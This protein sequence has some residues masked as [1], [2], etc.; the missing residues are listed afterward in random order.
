[1]S[2]S[3]QRFTRWKLSGCVVAD[4]K[5]LFIV[6]EG[7]LEA[8]LE[9][10]AFQP[11]PLSDYFKTCSTKSCS[12]YYK[13]HHY[14]FIFKTKLYHWFGVLFSAVKI[15]YC[16]TKLIFHSSFQHY[17]FPFLLIDIILL[18]LL[19]FFIISGWSINVINFYMKIKLNEWV[20]LLF[21]YLIHWFSLSSLIN[22]INFFTLLVLL[23]FIKFLP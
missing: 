11:M 19:L 6:C 16:N 2:I 1:M 5:R 8:N 3:W 21:I 22:L 17:Q 4:W 20:Y 15:N 12:Q 10:R 23:M 7:C 18:L 14:I 9:W 13:H